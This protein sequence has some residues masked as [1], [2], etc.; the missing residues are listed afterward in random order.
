MKVLG[1]I[2]ARGGSRGIPRK[3]IQVL[4]DKPLIAYTIEHAL[5]A[6][7]VDRLVITTDASVIADISEDY[8]AEVIWRPAAISGDEASS[9]LAL[10]HALDYLQDTEG[11]EP[12]LVVFLQ[13]TSPIRRPEDI[14]EAVARLRSEAADS[15]VSVVRSHTWLWRI[16][17]GSP[18]SFNYDYRNRQRR[19]DRPVEYNENG[20]IYIFKPWVLRQFK[21]RLGGRIV[22]YEMDPWSAVDIEITEDLEF[23]EWLIHRCQGRVS[24][25]G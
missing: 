2:P 7:S 5:G 19:Q 25:D 10:L 23:A 16:F 24:E 22:L 21:N 1:I 3:N 20:S 9:E 13:A 11:Y 12:D 8:G 14:D 17:E 15:L 4:A 6:A 18:V